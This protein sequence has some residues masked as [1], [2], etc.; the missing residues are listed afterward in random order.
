MRGRREQGPRGSQPLLLR[1]GH[2]YEQGAL[3]RRAR[4]FGVANRGRAAAAESASVGHGAR[5]RTDGCKYVPHFQ[6]AHSC[7]RD[8]FNGS[9]TNARTRAHTRTDAHARTAR[10]PIFSGRYIQDHG[11]GS[12]SFSLDEQLS[13][14]LTRAENTHKNLKQPS[15][16][17]GSLKYVTKGGNKI[18]IQ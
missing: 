15:E 18:K 7:A 2:L 10:A 11:A 13:K 5:V 8:R 14:V 1:R 6:L 12:F 9:R 3:A 16:P 4:P 17:K